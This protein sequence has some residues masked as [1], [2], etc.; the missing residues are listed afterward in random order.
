M[1]FALAVMIAVSSVIGDPPVAAQAPEAAKR[2]VADAA[3]CLRTGASD[4]EN[5]GRVPTGSMISRRLTFVNESM[6]DA[7]VSVLSRTC[8]CLS[9]SFSAET[10]PP[11]GQTVLTLAVQVAPVSAEQEQVVRFEVLCGAGEA[12]RRTH[13]SARIRYQPTVSI[14]TI[15]E[16]I[17]ATGVVGEQLNLDVYLRVLSAGDR[18]ALR[19]ESARCEHQGIRFDGMYLVKDA[20]SVRLARFVCDAVPGE[21]VRSTLELKSASSREAAIRVPV[22]IRPVLPFRCSPGGVILS[23]AEPRREVLVSQRKPNGKA[24][25]P[26]SFHVDGSAGL[27]VAIHPSDNGD[28]EVSLEL[29]PASPPFGH[30]TVKL[31]LPDGKLAA[32]IPVAWLE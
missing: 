29:E 16:Q 20:P 3:G 23:R 12:Q 14:T 19:I 27:L 4:P 13:A 32:Q 9:A 26:S 17:V 21:V 6:Q 18:E 11:G 30:A 1:M 7:H 2:V 10:V 8:G 25:Q 24:P 15:P 5:M 28:A 31:L 22:L